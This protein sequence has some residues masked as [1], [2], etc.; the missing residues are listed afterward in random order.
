M[1]ALDVMPEPLLKLRDRVCGRCVVRDEIHPGGC[2]PGSTCDAAVE[3]AAWL[4]ADAVAREQVESFLERNREI[5]QACGLTLVLASI[6]HLIPAGDIDCWLD[7]PHL[8]LGGRSPRSCIDAGHWAEV[9]E[10]LWLSGMPGP[11]S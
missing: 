5:C 11:V 6:D 4:S 9:I 2:P 7:T 3:L 8:S 1:F 10:A